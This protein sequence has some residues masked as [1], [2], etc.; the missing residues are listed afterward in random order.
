MKLYSSW[1][2]NVS[3]IPNTLSVKN[4]DTQNKFQKVADIVQDENPKR[5][6]VIEFRPS[7]DISQKQWKKRTECIYIFTIDQNIVKIGGT[8]NGLKAR[9]ASYLCGHHVAE[10]GK[11]GKCSITNAVIYNTFDHCLREK[12]AT[13]IEMYAYFLPET[14]ITVNIL[15]EDVKVQAQTYHA[16]ES[17][18]VLQYKK[19]TGEYPILND[20]IDPS[21]TK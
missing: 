13:T 21:Y 3:C 1:V 2:K 16:Y 12:N 17:K 10:R 4:F 5:T 20:N 14:T 9:T 7:A 19:I 18:Y 11:S 15:G 8:R 6:T